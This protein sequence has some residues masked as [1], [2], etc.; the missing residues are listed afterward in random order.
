MSVSI[1][2]DRQKVEAEAGQNLLEVLKT[3][4]LSLPEYSVIMPSGKNITTA[5]VE[6]TRQKKVLPAE[7]VVVED[8][9]RIGLNS[10]FA[11]QQRQEAFQII[12]QEHLK[13]C[14]IC[15]QGQA[16]DYV[17]EINHYLDYDISLEGTDTS[18]IHRM[19]Q[20]AELDFDVCIG[21]GKCVA[22]CH[23]IGVDFLKLEGQGRE[24]KVAI[25]DDPKVDCIYCG[26]CTVNCPVK[27]AR[28]QSQI[29][30]VQEALDDDDLITIVQMAPSVR[31]SIGE[32]FGAEVGLN[33]EKKMFTAFR[34]LGFD[35]IFDVNMG[36]DIT[37]MVE[38]EE[39]VE[40]IKN[41]G[42]LPM[43]TSCC[44]GWVKFL[45]FYYPEMLDH[46]T[47]SRSPQIHSGAAYKTWW[48]EKVGIDPDKIR[49]IS[50]MP[51]TSKKYEAR[52]EKLKVD[53]R[54]PVDY[55]LTTRET[56][57]LLKQHNIDLME[58]EDSELD[59]AGIYS[60][61]GAIYG[62]SGGVM[63][64]ALRTAANMLEGKDLPKL[65]FEQVRGM[66]G[67]KK[68]EVKLAGQTIKVAVVQMAKNMH[69]LVK[70]VQENPEAYHYV[71]FMACPG[72][73]IGGGGQPIPA[74]DEK[75]AQRIKGLYKIDDSM[76]MRQAH[77]NKVA[78]DFLEYAH[79]S[80]EREEKLLYTHYAPKEK[81]E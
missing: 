45:E 48:A 20:A 24:R 69:E 25:S 42:T 65:E 67:I 38:A 47:E 32:E 73:C 75:T 54:W 57:Y 40:R 30:Q 43:F 22:A 27:S 56:A 33:L 61:A 41:D 37:T 80:Q 74:D 7:E 15:Q 72:G 77:E 5:L 11:R 76:K 9:M 17:Q 16:C 31:A 71:E 12:K 3:N 4:N 2:I 58:L 6:D 26:Q 53:G 62:A 70:E 1:R 8:R 63:E 50:I 68:A 28:E 52:H 60:G 21:C 46:L 35:H 81:F 59:D 39:L 55:V 36:A 29:Q 23:K 78:Q 49:V 66:Q 79:I 13:T 19:A 18:P 51:C 34:Q 64:S 10:G 14:E 44:P